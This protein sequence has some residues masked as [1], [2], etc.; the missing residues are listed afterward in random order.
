MN[1]QYTSFFL[2]SRWLQIGSF[3]RLN[4]GAETKWFLRNQGKE[5]SEHLIAMLN[6]LEIHQISRVDTH[7]GEDIEVI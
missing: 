5:L 2:L 7:R 6:T 4:S 1:K 3:R